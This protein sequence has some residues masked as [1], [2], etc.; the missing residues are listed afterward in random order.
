V[1]IVDD[2]EAN[3]DILDSLLE[4]VGFECVQSVDGEDALNQMRARSFDLVLMDIRMPKLGGDEAIAIIR[5]DP[6]LKDSKVIAITASVQASLLDSMLGLGFDDVVG[7]PFELPK[8]LV[9]IG[10]LLDLDVD[11]VAA[12]VTAASAVAATDLTVLPAERVTLLSDAIREALDLGDIGVLTVLGE[13][14]EAEGG[15]VADV[16]RKLRALG[17]AFDFDGLARLNAQLT[18][19]PSKG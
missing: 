12:P 4:G 5:A 18:G 10:K 7:K 1:L 6:T 16:G 15:P 13:E 3:R 8:L 2:I 14:L 17:E 9:K 19:L 11:T